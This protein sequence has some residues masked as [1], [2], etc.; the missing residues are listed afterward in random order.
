MPA[1]PMP[2]SMRRTPRGAVRR[3]AANAAPARA[4][5]TTPGNIALGVVPQKASLQ[6]A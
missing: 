4:I 3:R 5:A 2:V 1:A 6:S